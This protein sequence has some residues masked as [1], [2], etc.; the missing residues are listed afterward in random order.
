MIARI[1]HGRTSATNA[2]EYAEFVGK[3]GIPDYRRTKGNLGA[4][5][6][7]RI[8]GKEAH[9]LTVSFWDSMNSIKDF[10]GEDVG[11]AKYYPDDS[12]Y[13]LEFEPNVLH[14][15]VFSGDPMPIDQLHP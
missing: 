14:Y 7:R 12:K 1:W 13:L 4:L 5:V 15:E 2:E 8:D 11:K 10:A 6:L 3:T 9:F